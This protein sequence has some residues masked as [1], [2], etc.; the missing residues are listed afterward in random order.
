MKE[1]PA[2]VEQALQALDAELDTLRRDHPDDFWHAWEQR[3][4]PIIDDT[5]ADARH[6][7]AKR[8]D[9]MLVARRLGPADP[10]S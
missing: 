5:P 8:L 4:Q 1:L 9:E 6:L 7:V 3:C 2:N 10:G